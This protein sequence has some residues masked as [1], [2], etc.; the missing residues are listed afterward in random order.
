MSARLVTPQNARF[1]RAFYGLIE[2]ENVGDADLPIPL[3]MLVSGAGDP[4]WPEGAQPGS[5][6]E[7][8]FLGG[9]PGEISAGVLRPGEK[10]RLGF[11]V[12]PSGSVETSLSLFS[13]AGDSE[14]AFDWAI[15]FQTVE[16][17]DAHPLWEEAVAAVQ[18][19]YPATTYGEFLQILGDAADEMARY[20][21]GSPV[22]ADIVHYMI[23]REE[24]FL[25]GAKVE[26]KLYLADKT[27]LCR[28]SL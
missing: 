17:D 12:L 19:K 7:L 20:H 25:P 10:R 3:L 5:E 21:I 27:R 11:N 24:T 4:V 1:G 16:P 8:Q 18:S 2:Y 9:N 14:E 28:V 6:T 23:L 22:V 26:G 13:K 15:Y